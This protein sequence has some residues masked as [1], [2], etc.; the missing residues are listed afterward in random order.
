MNATIRDNILINNPDV[1]DERLAS[2]IDKCSLRKFLDESS[3][4][5]NTMIADNGWQLSEGIRRRIAL[6]RA[7]ATDGAL[8]A[9]DEP[10]ESLDAEGC[11]AVYQALAGMAEQGRTIIV[12]SH[13]SDI[14]KG[15]HIQLDLNSKPAPK[16]T[17]VGQ[18]AL[19]KPDPKLPP[20]D[21]KIEKADKA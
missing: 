7:L 11:R 1:D 20:P 2:V 5:L 4:G 6:G 21:P 3:E 8:V 12:M 19:P 15:L 14:V 10:T 16:I 13:D 9:I 17:R 18:K